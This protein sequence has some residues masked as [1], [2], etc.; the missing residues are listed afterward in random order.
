MKAKSFNVHVLKFI[1][2]FEDI[3]EHIKG[4]ELNRIIDGIRTLPINITA[5]KSRYLNS[6]SNNE[7]AEVSYILFNI[8]HGFCFLIYNPF[9][10]GPNSFCEYINKKIR[11]LSHDDFIP[12]EKYNTML[13]FAVAH[14]VRDNA[15]DE[16][17]NTIS[18]RKLEYTVSST[19]EKLTQLFLSENNANDGK[20]MELLRH[21]VENSGCGR[22]AINLS[23]GKKRKDKKTKTV[24]T[25]SLNKN[26][27]K[28]LFRQTEDMLRENQN[29]Q[30]IVIDDDSRIIDLLYQRLLYKINVEIENGFL[31]MNSVINQMIT[32]MEMKYGEV[33]K[34]CR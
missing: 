7:L 10:G 23:A 19:P 8:D 13:S 31:S 32:L 11:E 9:V 14:I 1:Y 6:G 2:Q 15:F 22:I 33:T 25:P 18:V 28:R 16:F 26:F 4:N 30:F 34:Y 17:N 5:S 12:Y 3:T 20:G 24:I 21:F 29:N 27:L